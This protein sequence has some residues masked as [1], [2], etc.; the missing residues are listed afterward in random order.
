MNMT[1]SKLLDITKLVSGEKAEIPFEFCPIAE[2][3]QENDMSISSICFSGRAF[4]L[5][6]F[7]RLTGRVTAVLSAPCARCLAPVREDFSVNVDFPIAT[8][9]VESEEETLVT[10]S[11][12]I[13]LQELALETIYTNLPL[14]L[15]CREDCKG[16]C[17]KC[18]VNWNEE[19]CQ[20]KK[21][22]IDPR[23]AGLA[24]FFK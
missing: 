22:E 2:D 15:L 1:E 18:G 9:P 3:L 23:L 6:G 11:E 21:T 16:L 12:K 5:S 7:I 19:S 10:E 4:D 13:D 20:C 17:P 24:D 8:E 14:R